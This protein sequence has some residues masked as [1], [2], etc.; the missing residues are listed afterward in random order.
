[1]AE[2][3]QIHFVMHGARAAIAAGIAHIEQQVES[4]ERAV[5]ENPALVFDLAKT[6]VESVCRTVLRDRAIA[7]SETDDLP[8]LFKLVSQ[9]LPFLP[10]SVSSEGEIRKSL[11]K[12][13]NGLHTAILGICELRNQCGFASHGAGKPRPALES[14]QALLA[15]ETADTIIGFLHRVHQQDRTTPTLR[16]LYGDNSAF[17]DWVDE[18][19]GPIRIF[20]IEFRP[21]DVLFQLEPESYRVYLAEFEPESEADE[22]D[23]NDKSQV[24]ETP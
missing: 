21:S 19:Y 13:I 17:N 18:Q 23:T 8:R 9:S 1:M 15:A 11:D 2:P 4:L 20:E 3:L 12:T 14:V 6:V 16:V 24:Q 10:P 7:F 22:V 5:I